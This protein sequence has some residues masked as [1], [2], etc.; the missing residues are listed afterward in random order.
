MFEQKT[1]VEGDATASFTAASR[2]SAFDELSHS[3][4]GPGVKRMFVPGGQILF[5]EDEIA[6]SLYIVISGCLGVVMRG[7]N[8]RD[9]LVARIAAGETIGEM[10]L[11]DGGVRSATIEALR[12][13]ELL[14]FDKASYEDLLRRDPKSIHALVSL[15]VRRLRKTTHPS[16]ATA[17]P[18]RTVAVV[19]LGLDVD[20]RGIADDLQKQVS[21]NGQRAG[22]R[23]GGFWGDAENFRLLSPFYSELP[24]LVAIRS[25]KWRMLKRTFCLSRHWRMSIY[26][27]GRP[28]TR[29]SRPAIDMRLKNSSSLGSRWPVVLAELQRGWHSKFGCVTFHRFRMT[30]N[31]SPIS[32]TNW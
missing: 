7:S 8:G 31:Y 32:F 27:I 10:G 29:R 6:D 18:I 23:L 11:L 9:V 30:R 14:K 20:H 26:W 24:R 25:R 21:S 13:T 12:D 17:L 15:L 19:P 16:N 3:A 4:F 2:S 22:F 1:F 28:V 5:R